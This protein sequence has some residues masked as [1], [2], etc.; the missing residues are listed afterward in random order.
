MRT[1]KTSGG[2]TTT[3]LWDK[4]RD[5][6]QV[7]VETTG[8]TV[9]TYSYGHH[10]INQK[11]SGVGTRFYHYDGQHSTRQLTDTN[12]AVTDAYT[13]DAFGVLLASNGATPNNH[14]YT[15]EQLDANV[16]F[17]YLRARYYAQSTGRFITTD[18]FPGT[19]FDPG[20]LHRYLYANSNPVN[21]S[22]P[23]G[24]SPL[25]DVLLTSM[26]RGLLVGS[27]FSGISAAVVAGGGG[28]SDQVLDAAISGF[29]IGFF[30]GSGSAV[31][32]GLFGI[33]PSAGPV[34]QFLVR[35][36]SADLI[37]Q[38]FGSFGAFTSTLSIGGSGLGGLFGLALG[39]FLNDLRLT[40]IYSAQTEREER[41][42]VTFRAVRNVLRHPDGDRILKALDTQYQTALRSPDISE[43]RRE[44]LFELIGDLHQAEASLEG[45]YSPR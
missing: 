7:A 13:F 10:L 25:T 17:Y 21:N 24:M 43:E 1:A 14:L 45:V 20:S 44:R 6:A 27:L 39:N 32:G 15:G 38:T 5:H 40:A 28:T 42:A 30:A 33:G 35:A 19:L 11:R 36:A 23:S 4:N 3:F 22:D 8:T 16:G 18:P 29:L 31:A 9:V 26:I 12:R 37:F 2:V 34:T 41:R